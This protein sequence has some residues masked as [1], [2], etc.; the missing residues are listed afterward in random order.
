MPKISS[1]ESIAE[2]IPLK[3]NPGQRLLQFSGE[4]LICGFSNRWAGNMSLCYADRQDSLVNRKI[5][6]SWLGVRQ[7]N[8]VCAKQAHGSAV[9]YVLP[10]DAGKGAFSYEGSIADTDAFVTDEKNLALAMFTADCL[11]VFFYD[12]KRKV[13]GLAHAG[14]RGSRDKVTQKTI[15]FM[16][17]TFKTR[18][19]DLYLGL[20]PSIRSCCYEVS[21]GMEEAFPGGLLKRQGKYYLDLIATNRRQALDCGAQEERIF[22]SRICTFCAKRNCFSFRREGEIAGRMIS[23]IMLK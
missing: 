1:S 15:N 16:R 7:D 17:E 20:G 19:E 2:T 4:R 12:P 11:S 21:P 18:P 9:K 3:S 8:L 23:V 13:I 22:D 14:W 5:F 10:Q 6:L